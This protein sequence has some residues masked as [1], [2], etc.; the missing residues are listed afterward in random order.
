MNMLLALLIVAGVV[1][2]CVVVLRRAI[3]TGGYRRR[4]DNVYRSD[5]TE[6]THAS[7]AMFIASVG[8]PGGDPGAHHHA[9]SHDCGA[10]S[11]GGSSGCDGGN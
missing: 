10:T 3:E 2:V 8:D 5:R 11:N 7:G 4:F 1:A 6:T 9:S